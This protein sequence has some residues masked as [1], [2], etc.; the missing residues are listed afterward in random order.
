MLTQYCPPEKLHSILLPR[1]QWHPFPTASEQELWQALP[2]SIRQAYTSLAEG[3]LE[4]RWPE[5]QAVRFLDYARNGNRTR[6]E[7]DHFARR[8]TLT[9]LV[10]AECM[11][12]QGRFVDD[13]VNGVWAICEESFWGVPAHVGISQATSGLPDT[14]DPTVDLFAAET[15]ALLAWTAYLLEPQLDEVSPLI[16]PRIQRELAYRILQPCLE[17]D[18]FWWMGLHIQEGST[19]RVN[20]WNPW[21]CSNW[22]TTALLAGRDEPRR[23]EAI[24]KIMACL[25]KFIDFYPADGGCDEGPSY[26][27]WASG[28]LS[29]C[30]ELLYSAT[31]GR[32]DVYDNPLI[33]NMGRYI[34]RTQISGYYFV[35]FADASAVTSTAPYITFKYGQR[36]G[37]AQ[38]SQL[39]A[40]LA[41]QEGLLEHGFVVA[42]NQNARQVVVSVACQLPALFGLSEIQGVEP[43]QPLPRDVWLDQ[44]EVMVA[45]DQDGS[46]QGLFV[47][48]KGGHNNESHNHNDVGNFIV[49]I[50]G[51]PVLVDAG[52][53]TYT[54]KTFGPQRYEIW[55]MQSAYHNLP[56]INGIMQSAG[57][58]FAATAVDYRADE[59][60]AQLTLDI[61]GAY[62]AE[63]GLESWVR[64]VRLD[65]GRGVQII[66]T[67][68]LSEPPQEMTMSLITPCD[69]SL[70]GDDC[71]VLSTAPM[72][73][74]RETGAGQVDLE[75]DKFSILI[76]EIPITDER[77]GGIWGDRLTRI[78]LTA[79]KPLQRDTR[80]LGVKSE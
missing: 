9:A 60:T 39:G 20:N 72:A 76:E 56:T 54:A 38:M 73:N 62:P 4:C 53:E 66:D 65:R 78:I 36:I 46:E 43:V 25:D 23:T 70:V 10:L 35:N 26:W 19:A 59:S 64:T 37:D 18:D 12:G 74:D 58:A 41:E 22:L 8:H 28:S 77:L 16:L 17:R 52:V 57:A 44:I 45:R 31:N 32:F 3:Y 63:A 13:I 80:T 15:A 27:R 40:W 48:A 21:I 2:Q 6:F 51:K 68:A 1:E 11:E 67:F 42:A 55:T 79:K 61:A 50:D 7:K 29:S 69:V 71:I 14:A 5:L 49:Y 47:A 34:Y 33:Q 24:S 75:A 30:L